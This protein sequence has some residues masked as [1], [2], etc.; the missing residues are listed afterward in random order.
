MQKIIQTRHRRS[1]IHSWNRDLIANNHLNPTD[2]IMPFFVIEG[3]N[4]KIAIKDMDGIYRFSIDLLIDEVK[5]CKELGIKAVMIFPVIDD[6]KKDAIGSNAIDANNLICRA[7]LEIKKQV[8]NI[9]VIADIALDPFTNHG[10]DG[11]LSDDGKI[12]DNDKTIKILAKQALN[13][14]KSGCDIVAPSDMMDFTVDEIRKIL[15]K[16]NFIN[17]QIMSYSAKFASNYYGPF[18]S[19]LDLKNKKNDK[20]NYQFD[21]RNYDEFLNKIEADI[22]YG[23]D[24]IIIKPALAYL[25]IINKAK[26]QF[27]V[28]IIAYQVSL[29]YQMMHLAAKQ[30]LVDYNQILHENLIAIKRAGAD[31]IISYAAMDFLS[32]V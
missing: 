6:A 21:F 32:I 14:A 15:D 1:K 16:N 8:D 17:V 7:I 20:K 28:P 30:N 4:K 18:R 22:S 9:G 27:N 2:F 23:A 26:R 24:N 12:V 13:Y 5:K 11:V 19:A 3:N 29:E 25:D 10:H 31:I